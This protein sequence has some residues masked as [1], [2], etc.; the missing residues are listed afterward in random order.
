M[1]VKKQNK[2]ENKKY[3]YFVTI[4]L[5]VLATFFICWGQVRYGFFGQP[6]VAGVENYAQPLLGEV[7]T[8]NDPLITKANDYYF[9]FI[10]AGDPVVAGQGGQVMVFCDFL[11]PDCA[12]VWQKL[13]AEK[14]RSNLT[15]VWKNFPSTIKE[16]G[17]QAMAASLCA[18][19][20]NKFTEVADLMFAN[21]A[22]LSTKMILKLAAEAGLVME[23]FSACLE[24]TAVIQL[25]GQ[26][27]ADGQNLMIDQV[28][29]LFVGNSRVESGQ[30]N[31]LD[32]ILEKERP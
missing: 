6:Q 24:S 13:K 25:L 31:D 28:P 29:Y 19:Q 5:V 2:A 32:K 9:S 20:Q 26:D 12:L 21:Q 11:S 10:R 4:S 22:K 30:I 15:I 7:K 23:N 18:S 1:P 27:L 8:N 16:T 14:E 3:N 17:Q